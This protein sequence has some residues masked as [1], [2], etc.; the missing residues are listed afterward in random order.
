MFVYDKLN[1]KKFMSRHDLVFDEIPHIWYE[2]PFLGNGF[3]GA[4][5]YF[6]EDNKKMIISLGHTCIYDNRP[7]EKVS[8]NMLY[9]TP[10]LPVGKT[11]IEFDG[12]VVNVNLRLDLY[13]ARLYGRVFTTSGAVDID[14]MI[15]NGSDCLYLEHKENGGEGV[16]ITYTPYKAESPRYNKGVIDNEDKYKKYERAKP[17]KSYEKNGTSAYAQPYFTKGG[18]CVTQNVTDSKVYTAVNYDDESTE[19]LVQNGLTLL[20]NSILNTKNLIKEHIEWWNAFYKKSLISI[21]DGVYESFVYIQ[22]YKLACASRENGRP[23]DTCG[24][25][26]TEG[27]SWPGTWW[28]LNVELTISPLYATNHIELAHCVNNMLTKHFDDLIN[29]VPEKYRSDCAALGRNTTKTLYA[30]I[31]EPGD[32][33]ATNPEREAGNLTWILFYIWQEYRMTGNDELINDIVYPLLKKAIKFYS[34]FLQKDKNGKLHLPATISPEYNKSDSPDTNYDLALIRWGCKTLKQINEDFNLNDKDKSLWDKILLTLTDYPKSDE[35][36]LFIAAKIPYAESHRHYSHLL[37]F[38]PLHILSENKKRERNLVEKSIEFWQS[39][40]EALQGYSQSG[41]ASMYAMLGN[42]NK[43]I[44]HLENLW[45][46]FIKPNTMYHESGNP[47]LETPPSAVTSIVEMLVQ[48]HNGYIDFFPSV[49]DCWKNICFDNLL[50][51]DGFEVGAKLTDGK[52]EWIRITSRLGRKCK[53]KV[54]F[55]AE[56]RYTSVAYRILSDGLMTINL[57]AGENAII[58][59]VPSPIVDCVPVSSMTTNCYGLN[60]KN[61]AICG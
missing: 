43:A 36:G 32:L 31:V 1:W 30:P 60:K 8:D 9:M 33:N 61:K 45:S 50:C 54:N 34:Y 15:F 35:E 38:Y 47:V 53:I 25:W 4:V 3:M 39:K 56:P 52:V 10:R 24:P 13:Y 59:T 2:A 29:N 58:S 6:S 11:E 7:M 23:F 41:A 57:E 44:K 21:D 28:N 55:E 16:K 12:T 46:G 17:L 51:Y 26:L 22:L 27:T 48:S 20:K 42:G 18:F 40:P 14:C 37:A 5:V 19:A 49:P